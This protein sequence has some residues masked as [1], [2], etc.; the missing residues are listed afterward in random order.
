MVRLLRTLR[1]LAKVCFGRKVTLF[2]G[3]RQL[4]SIRPLAALE[5][6]TRTRGHTYVASGRS[7]AGPGWSHISTRCPE[8]KILQYYTSM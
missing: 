2:H 5:R 4:R 7:E 8:R 1:R 6:D 3:L